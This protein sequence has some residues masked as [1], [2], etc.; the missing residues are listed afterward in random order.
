MSEHDVAADD[1]LEEAQKNH[2]AQ[3]AEL[4]DAVR[5][6]EKIRDTALHE[7]TDAK[8][9]SAREVRMVPLMCNHT[10]NSC[11]GMTID[12]HASVAT[13]RA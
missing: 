9:N 3:L 6:A 11:H 2:A 5:N 4:Q 10:L 13:A 8:A 12:C 1:R 7:L